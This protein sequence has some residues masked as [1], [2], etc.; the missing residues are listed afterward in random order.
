VS[1]GSH[2]GGKSRQWYNP[3]AAVK[4]ARGIVAAWFSRQC[5]SETLSPQEHTYLF[6]GDMGRQMKGGMAGDEGEL[7]KA[8]MLR[9]HLV[10]SS[11]AI[12][13]VE[14]DDLFAHGFNHARHIVARVLRPAAVDHRL[15]ICTR[16]EPDC[17]R[18]RSNR[19]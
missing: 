1:A 19:S 16:D 10:E 5:C 12:A 2:G 3:T 17:G 18:R 11:H 13:F 6:K 14:P 8:P 7:G 9:H 4:A 15:P